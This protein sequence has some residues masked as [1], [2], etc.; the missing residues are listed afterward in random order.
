MYKYI[1]MSQKEVKKY[2]IIK[3]LINQEFKGPEAARLL[4]LTTRQ[5]RRLK[6]K[7]KEKGISGLIHGN[8]G[9]PS[10]RV[11][12]DEEKQQI[13]DLLHKHY[14][15][16]GPL[17]ASEKLSECHKIKRDKGTIRSI[18]INE[19]FWKPKQKKKEKHRVWR[20]RKASYGEMIQYDGS[21]EYWFEDRGGKCC[22][23]AGID[24]A[25][26]NVWIKFDEHEGVEPTFNFWRGYLERFGKPYSIYVDKFSTYSMNHKLARENPDTLTQFERAMKNDLNIDVIHTHSPEAKGRVEKLFHTLQ[27]RLIKE[28]RLNNIST[29]KEANKFLEEKFLP[30]FNA[31]FMVEPRTK[32]NLHKELTKKEKDRLDSIFS[33]QYERVVRNDFTINHKNNCYQLDKIQPATICKRD[34][35]T[36]EE[37]MDKTINFRLRGKYLNYKLLPEKPKKISV[38]KTQWVIAASSNYKPPV[39]HPWRQTARSEYLKTLTKMS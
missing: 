30:K 9:K 7:V 10:N 4:N 6:K 18:M 34:I 35:V 26:S 13:I 39:D 19:G 17:L 37:R 25:T 32:A 15:D 20:Q 36:V 11:I 31:K 3:K 21:Y 24:D 23:L 16:F 28:L 27:D 2:N 1:T 14:H 12:P 38:S 5:I 33:R 29:I 8:R 22:L